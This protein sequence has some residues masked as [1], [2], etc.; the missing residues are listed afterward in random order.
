MI[1]QKLNLKYKVLWGGIFCK[2][3]IITNYGK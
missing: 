2:Y 1:Y 3:N